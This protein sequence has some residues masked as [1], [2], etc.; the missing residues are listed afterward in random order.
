MGL[1]RD[2]EIFDVA[3]HTEH[4]TFQRTTRKTASGYD[5]PMIVHD[6]LAFSPEEYV[7]RYD[8]IQSAMAENDLDAPILMNLF[9]RV[10]RDLCSTASGKARVRKKL[11]RF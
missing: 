8:K 9:S 4:V 10:V 2:R 6:R 11:P 7:R 5:L 3:E 1:N